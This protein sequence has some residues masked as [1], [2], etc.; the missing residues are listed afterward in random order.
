ML[1]ESARDS[2]T[3]VMEDID[4]EEDEGVMM[5]M[6]MMRVVLVMSLSQPSGAGDEGHQDPRTN[7]QLQ[8]NNTK[9]SRVM[10]T[11]HNGQGRS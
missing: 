9:T 6:V 4:T 2:T 5:L 11:I 1:H 10:S 3:N 7:N 8:R